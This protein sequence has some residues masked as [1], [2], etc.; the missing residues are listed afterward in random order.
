MSS[1]QFP[2]SAMDIASTVPVAADERAPEWTEA[3]MLPSMSLGADAEQP[4]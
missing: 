2:G 4:S 3:L 1:G